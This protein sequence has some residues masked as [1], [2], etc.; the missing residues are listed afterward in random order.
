MGSFT[1]HATGSKIRLIRFTAVFIVLL[2][3]LSGCMYPEEELTKNQIPYQD[4]IQSVQNAVD[5]FQKDNNGILPIKTKEANTPYYQKYPID[6][7]KIVPRYMAEPPGNAYESGGV[8]Q[9]VLIDEEKNPTVKLFDVRLADQV[10]DVVIR[11]NIYRQSHGYP[12]FKEIISPNVYTLDHK[13]MGYK[14]PPTVMSPYT[15]K[16]LHLVIGNDGQ[17]YVDYTP[18]LIKALKEKGK[19]LSPGTDIRGILT[20]DS[21]FVPAYSLPYSIDPK[22]K[23]PIFINN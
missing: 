14:E 18:D 20:E 4:Q 6:F 17:I 15:Q 9:Y 5:Q 23:K 19:A 1:I 11:L 12:P 2:S 10:Q 22:T 16:E 7:K 21:L 13:K 8:F 3:L